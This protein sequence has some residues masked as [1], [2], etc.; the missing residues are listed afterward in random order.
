MCVCV[1]VCMYNMY[2]VYNMYNIFL[3][4]IFTW[5]KK[6]YTIRN[7]FCNKFC[8]KFVVNFIFYN[9]S[10]CVQELCKLLNPSHHVSFVSFLTQHLFN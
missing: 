10:L 7:K 1:Y 3:F 4:N 8:N 9:T 6:N 5:E 2:N